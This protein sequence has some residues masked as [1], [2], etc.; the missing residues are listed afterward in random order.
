METHRYIH[1]PSRT[2][3]P[4]PLL[5]DRRTIREDKKKGNEGKWRVLKGRRGTL[6]PKMGF[7][8]YVLTEMLTAQVV[9]KFSQWFLSLSDLVASTSVDLPIYTVLATVAGW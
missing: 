3:L 2:W 9:Y 8:N 4:L 6:A 1:R 5:G 7:V